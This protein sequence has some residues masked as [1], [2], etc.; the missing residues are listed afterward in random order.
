MK[1]YQKIATQKAN[2]RAFYRT[3]HRHIGPKTLQFA[4]FWVLPAHL[5]NL[6]FTTII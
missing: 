1:Y 6:K 4:P 5:L 3:S 2:P